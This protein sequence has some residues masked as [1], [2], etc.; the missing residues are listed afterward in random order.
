M[1]IK[2]IIGAAALLCGGTGAYAIGPNVLNVGQPLVN[3]Y[4]GEVTE[5]WKLVGYMQYG[6]GAACSAVQISR[7]WVVASAHC[8]LETGVIFKNG[9]SLTALGSEVLCEDNGAQ[10]N[11]D[12][13]A[14]RLKNPENFGAPAR[15]PS[16][17]AGTTFDTA[18]VVIPDDLKRTAHG[19]NL[20]VGFQG[21]LTPTAAF[22]VGLTTLNARR[23]IYDT[24]TQDVTL[25]ASYG[26]GGGDSGGGRFWF[27][28]G[29]RAP[30]LAGFTSAEGSLDWLLAKISAFGNAAPSVVSV[31]DLVSDADLNKVPGGLLTPPKIVYQD[32][33]LLISWRPE[34]KPSGELPQRFHIYEGKKGESAITSAYV[35]AD[36]LSYVI[37]S[38]PSD[39]A[40]R[41]LCVAPEANGKESMDNPPLVGWREGGCLTYSTRPLSFVGGNFTVSTAGGSGVFRKVSVKISSPMSNGQ[42]HLIAN[43]YRVSYTTQYAGG[44]LRDGLAVTSPMTVPNPSLTL[45][46]ST[47]QLS[48]LPKTRICVRVAPISVAGVVGALSTPKCTNVN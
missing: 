12:L 36:T 45:V 3:P 16:I 46:S 9:Y 5:V 41:L 14:C 2:N 38:I 6:S 28:G 22:G 21:G 8:S 32:G 23:S 1:R 19:S 40:V 34:A 30:V 48:V 18:V 29:G 43:A 47:A 17:L 37:P 11:M 15:Y 44:A 31:A 35:G 13:S 25:A 10:R 33:R 4:T 39:G 24:Y 27:P 7:E 26:F 42:R 20:A